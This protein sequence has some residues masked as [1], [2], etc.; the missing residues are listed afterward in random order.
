MPARERKAVLRN[1]EQNVVGTG[2]LHDVFENLVG[3]NNDQRPCGQ[4]DSNTDTRF[5]YNE[6][7]DAKGYD[8][9][10]VSQ[11]CKMG[12]EFVESV[13]AKGVE[14]VPNRIVNKRCMSAKQQYER[15]QEKRQTG[16]AENIRE[17]GVCRRI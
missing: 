8:H 12:Y 6:K 2:P 16:D 14:P 7:G 1:E 9:L 5:R 3:N 11:K 4:W 10:P 17:H 15:D 13:T